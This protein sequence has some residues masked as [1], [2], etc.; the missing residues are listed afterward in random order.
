MMKATKLW[1]ALAFVVLL[2]MA[3]AQAQE[4]QTIRLGYAMNDASNQGHGAKFFADAVSRESAGKFK[5][6]PVGGGKLGP[7][8]QAVAALEKGSFEMALV[9]TTALAQAASGMALWDAPFLFA[10][11][12]QVDAVLDGPIGQKVLAQL[13]SRGVVGLVYWEFGFRQITNSQREIA[14]LEDLNGLNLRVPPSLTPTFAALGAVPAAV[15]FPKIY[16]GLQSKAID[17][18]E[19]PLS[20]ILDAR[21][22]EVQDH[23]TLSN[24]AYGA[25][26]LLVGK[27]W[28]SSR[29][30][31]ERAMLTKAAIS[32]REFERSYSREEAGHALATLKAN[33]MQVTVLTP[34]ETERMQDRVRPVRAAIAAAVGQDL[35][36]DTQAAIESAQSKK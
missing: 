9:S 5:V 18:Q 15:P 12:A 32:S 13:G 30:D 10:T 23:V 28:W 36:H 31:T 25:L 7:E 14:H 26:V 24:H 20:V 27:A 4:V 19:H 3:P 22:Y 34:Q 11:T 1:I 21:F 35:W 6:E 17:G 29:T 8:S 2:N 16:P 33:G